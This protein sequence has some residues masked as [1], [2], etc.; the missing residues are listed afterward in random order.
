[1]VKRKSHLASNEI[2]QVRVLVGLL[3]LRELEVSVNTVSV[4]YAV[5]MPVCEA[6]GKGSTPFGHPEFLRVCSWESSQLPNL[7]H[8][9]RL[10]AL[11]LAADVARWRM[12][13]V[14]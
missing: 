12:T 14:L 10:L 13:P 8:K 3:N 2:F 7:A 9:V 5:G 4:V 11:V 1:M 6:G